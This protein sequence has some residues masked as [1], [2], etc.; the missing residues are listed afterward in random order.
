MLILAW[1]VYFPL[2]LLFNLLIVSV[3]DLFPGL[4]SIL[5]M[6]CFSPSDFRTFPLNT[7][8]KAKVHP[9]PNV[10]TALQLN[11]TLSSLFIEVLF[12]GERVT[13]GSF[14]A[15]LKLK[16]INK[17]ANLKDIIT[18]ENMSSWMTRS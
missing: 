5:T 14:E 4:S 6:L 9:P 1:Q 8:S 3:E 10:S 7:H 16:I 11:V 2:S 15:V 12:F 17:I 18:L 13:E